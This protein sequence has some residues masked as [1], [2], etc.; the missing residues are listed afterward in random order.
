MKI[1]K[2][3]LLQCGSDWDV[4]RKAICAA[5][6]FQAAKSKSVT[7]Y[8]NLRSGLPMKLHPTSSLMGLGCA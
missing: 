8:S 1:Q 3:E 4:V 6:F 2:L 5:Y 7:E